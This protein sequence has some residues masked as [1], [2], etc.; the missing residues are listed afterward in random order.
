MPPRPREEDEEHE[1][2]Q[3][4]ICIAIPD[5]EVYQCREGHLVCKECLRQHRVTLRGQICPTCRCSMVVKS[6][7]PADPG[8]LFRGS[9][10]AD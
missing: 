1:D 7:D 6:L 10:L 8:S 9:T 5:G 2:L 4:S 3:C